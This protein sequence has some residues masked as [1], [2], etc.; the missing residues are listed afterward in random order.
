M[1]EAALSAIYSSIAIIVFLGGL[2]Y[3]M[4]VLNVDRKGG[5]LAVDREGA[6][7]LPTDQRKEGCHPR[8]FTFG[9]ASIVVICVTMGLILGLG[10]LIILLE[11]L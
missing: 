6:A 4:S 11:L 8:D 2:A 10:S 9:E 7:G 1:R 3:V 5:F